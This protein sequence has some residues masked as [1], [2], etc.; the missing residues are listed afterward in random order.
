M[1]VIAVVSL[2]IICLLA[3][4]CLAGDWAAPDAREDAAD[5]MRRAE[6]FENAVANNLASAEHVL[7]EI[8]RLHSGSPESATAEAKLAWLREVNRVVASAPGKKEG[9]AEIDPDWAPGR[10]VPDAEE[11][12]ALA[13]AEAA[14]Q[15]NTYESL[16][17]AAFA[18]QA[19]LISHPDADGAWKVRQ[20]FDEVDARL[21]KMTGRPARKTLPRTELA[22]KFRMGGSMEG[23]VDM[24]TSVKGEAVRFEQGPVSGNGTGAY[25]LDGPRYELLV[26]PGE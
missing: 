9:R 18:C 4:T 26:V 2:M 3:G 20:R 6:K 15:E 12:A 14:I 22:R 17:N 23:L 5:M 1:R 25:S 24:A 13:L 11:T 16:H 7:K 19:Y 8:V 10:V 21:R